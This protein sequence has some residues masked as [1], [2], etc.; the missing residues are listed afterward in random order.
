MDPLT[1]LALAG[2]ALK[3]AKDAAPF[4]RDLI[5]SG[6]IPVEDQAK[7]RAAYESLRQQLGGEYTGSHWEL[8]GR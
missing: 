7:V 8:S 6:E 5:A 4:I 1:I 2:A 3:L